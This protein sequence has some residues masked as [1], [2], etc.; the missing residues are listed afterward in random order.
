MKTHTMEELKEA[1]GDDYLLK[2]AREY[3]VG[4]NGRA[5]N[6][7]REIYPM[8]KAQEIAESRSC[9]RMLRGHHCHIDLYGNVVPAGCT[10]IR[11]SIEDFTQQRDEL[12]DA[13]KHPVTARLLNGGSKALLDYA[14]SLGFDAETKAATSCDLCYQIRCF[15]RENAPCEDIGPDCFYEMMES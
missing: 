12:S 6:L 13:E 10:G 9:E 14:L 8:K 7:A 4:M 11:I 5:L 2:T 15:L 3:G 1:L